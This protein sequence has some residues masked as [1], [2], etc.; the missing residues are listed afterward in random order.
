MGLRAIVRNGRY[1]IDE[2]ATF[3]EGTELDLFVGVDDAAERAR[4]DAA[5]DRGAKEIA[6]GEAVSAETVLEELRVKFG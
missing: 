5:I 6:A 3:P 2:P 1:V 4:I